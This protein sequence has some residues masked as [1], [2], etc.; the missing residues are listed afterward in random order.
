MVFVEFCDNQ[1]LKRL[2]KRIMNV[3][4]DGVLVTS[5]K[6][7]S[8]KGQMSILCNLIK[9]FVFQPPRSEEKNRI[10]QAANSRRKALF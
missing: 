2:L 7:S 1:E 3:W 6:S 10:W 9:W 4:K 8:V 5:G